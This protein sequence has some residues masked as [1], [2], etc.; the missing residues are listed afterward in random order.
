MQ[1]HPRAPGTA[2]QGTLGTDGPGCVRWR[3][4]AV[5][6]AGSY[7]T[8]RHAHAHAHAHVHAPGAGPRS[9]LRRAHAHAERAGSR[10]LWPSACR[11]A[12]AAAHHPLAGRGAPAAP[13]SLAPRRCHSPHP[14]FSPAHRS[15]SA[16]RRSCLSRPAGAAPPTAHHRGHGLLPASPL[17]RSTQGC[18]PTIYPC[19][20]YRPPMARLLRSRTA[21]RPADG[22][23]IALNPL[24]NRAEP[25]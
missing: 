5:A 6:G 25:S 23:S 22:T 24:I 16:R 17:A 13:D 21:V 4:R 11:P 20:G 15:V 8:P 1:D 14:P 18:P 7:P 10:G 19:Q 2:R 12:R 3:G 9:V